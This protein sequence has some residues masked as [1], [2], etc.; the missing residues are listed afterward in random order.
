VRRSATGGL[1]FVVGV[2][3]LAPAAGAAERPCPVFTVGQERGVVSDPAL[4]EVSGLAAS[5][6]H[7]GV[8]WAHADSGAPP[9]IHA[10]AA[11]GTHLATFALDGAT[12]FDWEDIAVG[13]G[14][15]EGSFVYVGDIGDNGHVRADVTVYRVA[16]PELPVPAGPDPVVLDDVT[17]LTAAYPDGA[18]DAEA[19]L[20]DPRTG[21]L[22][23]VTKAITAGAKSEV[24]RFPAPQSSSGTTTLEHVATLGVPS[25][26][27][28]G[29][30]VTGGDVS[31]QGDEILLRT[32]S[33]A[34]AW[35]RDPGQSVTEALGGTGC[36]IPLRSEPQGEA[37]AYRLDGNA[38]VTTSEWSGEGPR[39]LFEY[40]A[41]RRPDGLIRRGSR[42]FVGNDVH[43]LHRPDQTVTASVG[44]GGRVT[45]TVRVQ[46]DGDRTDTILLRGAAGNGRYRVR[47][48][49]AGRTIT[50]NVVHGSA[51]VRH[52][53]PGSSVP[54]QIEV[55][56]LAAA[57]AGS[58]RTIAVL[59]SSASNPAVRDRVQ[60]VVH[61]R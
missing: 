50:T 60:A 44:P 43:G 6:A 12:A 10:L 5:R 9:E 32:Y 2:A 40:L 46:N 39:P 33:T 21:D 22:F 29:S 51:R 30:W 23:I 52:L 11:D 47:Y 15:D 34:F 14:P 53:A 38:Y 18:H 20:A 8:Y 48:L 13:P 27:R 41:R 54:I 3:L 57:P 16:E 56:A 1:A 31:P 61:R 55:T 4:I 35:R 17:A 45:F 42:P 36:P 26:P 25:T 7:P 19:L 59:L 58:S 37:I 24:Y 49:R 28:S